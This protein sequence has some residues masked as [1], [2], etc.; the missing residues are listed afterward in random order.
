MPMLTNARM[1]ALCISSLLTATMQP[2]NATVDNSINMFFIISLQYERLMVVVKQST[3]WVN[4]SLLSTWYTNG[5]LM[6]TIRQM[7]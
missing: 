2:I 3:D 4:P 5:S 6:S 7:Q 1:L